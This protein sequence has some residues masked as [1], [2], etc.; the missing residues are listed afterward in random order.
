M[1]T[2]NEREQLSEH[3]A[4]RDQKLDEIAAGVTSPQ[5][6]DILAHLLAMPQHYID[7]LARSLFERSCREKAPTR[8]ADMIVALGQPAIMALVVCLIEN[9]PAAQKIIAADL[10]FRIADGITGPTDL[11]RELTNLIIAICHVRSKRLMVALE[12]AWA[13][14]AKALDPL[15]TGTENAR[16]MREFF[17]LFDHRPVSNLVTGGRPSA[18]TFRDAGGPRTRRRGSSTRDRSQ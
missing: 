3:D 15:P 5:G 9:R 1:V 17:A 7:Y 6:D 14:V 13:A 2:A 12:R 18:V 16:V 10:V 11:E 4:L 8:F